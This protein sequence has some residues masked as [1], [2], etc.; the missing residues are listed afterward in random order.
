LKFS[1]DGL[2]IHLRRQGEV[3]GC[4]VYWFIKESGTLLLQLV[5]RSLAAALPYYFTHYWI[6]L[7]LC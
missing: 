7:L 3:K 1:L 4:V 2:H 6:L 5:I